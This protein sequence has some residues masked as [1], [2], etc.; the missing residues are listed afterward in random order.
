M[1]TAFDKNR[2][3]N[4]EQ[5]L[6]KKDSWYLSPLDSSLKDFINERLTL[7]STEKSFSQHFIEQKFKYFSNN[8]EES[9]NQEMK[10]K[11][12]LLEKLVKSLKVS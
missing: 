1:M 10:N 8:F 6:A 2:R 9:Y 3:L 11:N 12:S 4:C 5:I 7:N